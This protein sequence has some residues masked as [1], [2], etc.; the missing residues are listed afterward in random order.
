V[1]VKVVLWIA[2]SNQHGQL[3]PRFLGLMK[4]NFGVEVIFYD[5]VDCYVIMIIIIV[6]VI[7]VIMIIMAFIVIMV[8]VVFMVSMALENL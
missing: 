3:I 8:I 7:M 1:K 2:Y 4:D 6:I 5:F